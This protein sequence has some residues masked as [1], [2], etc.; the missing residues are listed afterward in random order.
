MT[1]SLTGSLAAP[2]AYLPPWTTLT[3]PFQLLRSGM[4]LVLSHTLQ[5]PRA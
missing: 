3:R 4:E 1:R 5:P 2:M